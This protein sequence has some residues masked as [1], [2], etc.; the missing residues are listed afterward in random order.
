MEVT[1]NVQEYLEVL[2]V[3][4]E[5]GVKLAKINEVA[6]ELRISPPSTVEMLKKMAKQGLVD[7]RTREGISLTEKGRGIARQVIRNHRLAELLLRDILEVGIDEEAICGFEH[8][9][10]EEI[11]DAVCS[12]LG[13][14]RRCPHGNSIPRGSCCL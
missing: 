9:I 10:S 14:P 13:H 6:G 1:E 8:H 4:E 3:F 7:Y 11:A 5:K 12:Y 2:W